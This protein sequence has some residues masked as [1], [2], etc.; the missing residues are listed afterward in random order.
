MHSPSTIMSP[1]SLFIKIFGGRVQAG[2]FRGLRYARQ[3]VGSTLLPKIFGT[4]ELEL[5]PQIERLVRYAPDVIVNIGAGEGY[6]AVGLACRLPHTQVVAYEIQAFAQ[7]LITRMAT[8]NHV[9][10][11]VAVYGLCQPDDISSAVAGFRRPFLVVDVEGAEKQ[12]LDPA[13][14]PGLAQHAMLVEIHDFTE[15]IGDLL[16]ARFADTHDHVEIWTQPRTARDL[17]WWLR[18]ITLT[19]WKSRLLSLMNEDR[20]GPMRWFYFEPRKSLAA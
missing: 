4:Y 18:P 6:Y 3:S 12:L 5:A 9:S 1:R 2:P 11:R 17:P 20:P 8:L 13:R 14:V 16:L 10:S 15:P 19:P 7:A